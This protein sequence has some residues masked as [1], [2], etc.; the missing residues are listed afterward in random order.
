MRLNLKCDHGGNEMML[1][2]IPVD[3]VA[4]EREHHCAIKTISEE[5]KFEDLCWLAWQ[6]ARRTRKTGQDFDA[7]L[8]D[9]N[10]IEVVDEVAVAPLDPALS[11][12]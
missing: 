12:G 5:Q 8:E 4:F 2:A 1:T 11:P 7:W 9:L 6:V 3:I 10:S